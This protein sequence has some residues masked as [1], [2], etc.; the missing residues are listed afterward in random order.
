MDQWNVLI[1]GRTH[2]II[3][4][5]GTLLG[6]GKFRIDNQPVR[7]M[8]V[9]VKKIGLFYPIEIEN[10]E[11]FLKC[12]LK[13]HPVDMVQDGRY[14]AVGTPLEQEI[15]DTLLQSV[16]ARDPLTA[17]DRSAMG[18]LLTFTVLTYVNMVL[19]LIDASVTFPFS[20]IVP[21]IV[22]ELFSMAEVPSV[23]QTAVGV[24]VSVALAS[25]YLFLYWR[26]R[27]NNSLWPIILSL[28]LVAADTLVVLFLA[29][30]D[31]SYYIIDI[32]FHLWMLWSLGQLWRVRSKKRKQLLFEENPVEY[33]VMK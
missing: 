25:V 6:K 20:A 23:F 28:I 10:S 5:G 13:N 18:S 29:L 19:F 22:L 33:T 3:F 8:A 2:E 17:K 14:L 7:G 24:L 26:A 21:E 32:A 9:M 4:E 1:N 12:D 30:D 16:E 15:Q 11:L 31:F 27:K